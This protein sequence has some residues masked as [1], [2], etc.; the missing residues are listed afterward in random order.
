VHCQRL[1]REVGESPSL[2]VFKNHGD[3]AARAMVSG[4]GKDGLPIG[5]DNLRALFQP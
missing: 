2:E 4:H 3:V 1:P 5:L